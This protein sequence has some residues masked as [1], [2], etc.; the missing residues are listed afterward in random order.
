MEMSVKPPTPSRVFIG[1][2][3][4]QQIHLEAL[5]R[6]SQHGDG[7]YLFLPRDIVDVYHLLPGDRVKVKLVES[8]RLISGREREKQ[9]VTRDEK[10]EPV[11]AIPRQ[12]RRRERKH[13]TETGLKREER[14]GQEEE[15]EEDDGRL[16]I[17]SHSAIEE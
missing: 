8:F 4:S 6:I 3:K 12:K 15:T 9:E 16:L 7:A 17:E 5:L 10:V 2:V 13:V 14:T 11:L 1:T